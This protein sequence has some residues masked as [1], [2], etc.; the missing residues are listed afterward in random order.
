LE[1]PLLIGSNTGEAN[2]FIADVLVNPSKLLEID[3]AWEDYYGP[4]YLRGRE[5]LDDV[6][7]EDVALSEAARDYFFAPDGFIELEKLDKLQRLVNNAA[8]W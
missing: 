2:L 3:A 1:V 4:F 5:G 6:L 8:F 7:Q